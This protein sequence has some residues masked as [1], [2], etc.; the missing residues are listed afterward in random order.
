MRHL[1]TSCRAFR[2]QFQARLLNP[3]KRFE[4]T[5]STSEK[6]VIPKR[7]HRGPTDILHALSA[8]VGF[9]PTAAHYK[10]HDDPFLIPQ[11]N[12]SKRSHALSQEAGR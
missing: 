10:Y 11:S 8:T 1:Y 2:A 3:P 7:I 9:D 12:L 5:T 6:I 4:S